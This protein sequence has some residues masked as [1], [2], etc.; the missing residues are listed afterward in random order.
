MKIFFMSKSKKYF[1]EK[2]IHLRIKQGL[3]QGQ[4]PDYR[5]WLRIQDVPSSGRSHRIYSHRTDRVYHLLS[6]LERAVF[7][8]LD[9]K[10]TTLDIREQFPL[11]LEETQAIAKEFGIRHPQ[12]AGIHQVMSSDFLV[13]TA[14]KNL[15]KFVLQ[16][17]PSADLEDKRT[18]EKLEIECR[19]WREKEI[20]FFVV[21]E[22]SFSQTIHKNLSW[23]YP[24][25]ETARDEGEILRMAEFY[26]GILAKLPEGTLVDIC[27]VIDTAYQQELGQALLDLRVLM[28]QRFIRFDISIP[29]RALTSKDLTPCSSQTIQQVFHVSR[30]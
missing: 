28:S 19:Y 23:L 30:K 14:D 17:K 7:F 29:W 12:I 11:I 4:G 21:S 27:K 15:P 8:I 26:T 3:G 16:V 9:W 13:D 6:D 25:Q 22:K 10:S 24:N 1:T 5:P 2:Q 18:I 20:P